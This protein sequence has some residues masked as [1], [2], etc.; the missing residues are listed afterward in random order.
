M[1]GR[2]PLNVGRQLQCLLILALPD[3]GVHQLGQLEDL[4]QLRVAH[5]RER[6]EPP[7]RIDLGRALLERLAGGDELGPL[8]AETVELLLRLDELAVD[9]ARTFRRPYER[10]VVRDG[11]I[12]RLLHILPVLVLQPH[13]LLLQ[14]LRLL[15]YRSRTDCEWEDLEDDFD[16]VPLLATGAGWELCC[17]GPSCEMMADASR[18]CDLRW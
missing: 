5:Q 2:Q 9:F 17:D 1:L 10:V 18:L 14:L 15:T 12:L 16:G 11:E 8:I 4:Q 13:F 6:I 7:G 3:A